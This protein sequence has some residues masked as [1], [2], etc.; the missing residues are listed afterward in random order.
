MKN[1]V[2]G[3]SF[4]CLLLV[5]TFVANA[6]TKNTSLPVSKGVQQYANKSAFTEEGKKSHIEA[7]SIDFPAVVISKGIVRPGDV[8]VAGNIESKGYPTWA[9]S[10]GVARQNEEKLQEKTGTQ[11]Y[12]GM[13]ISK[14]EN[15]ISKR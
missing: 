7:K 1:T 2:K 3:I 10:K 12:P 8:V 5:G 6:Q 9:I 13:D 15:Q 14:D 4:M 11:E